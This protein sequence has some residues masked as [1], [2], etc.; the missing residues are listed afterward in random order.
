MYARLLDHV[1]AYCALLVSLISLVCCVLLRTYTIIELVTASI[2]RSQPLNRPHARLQWRECAKLPAP[3]STPQTA[4]VGGR[5]YVGAGD[6]NNEETDFKVFS[7]DEAQDSWD[8]LPLCPVRRFGLGQFRGR[9]VA[10]GGRTRDGHGTAKVFCYDDQAQEWEEYIKPMPT[11]RWSLCIVT[12]QSA[13]VACGGK[14]A[15]NEYCEIV[16]LYTAETH[17][18]HVADALPIR[19]SIMKPVTIG[20][21]CYLM[22]GNGVS[23]SPTKAVLYASMS[24]LIKKAVKA[25]LAPK[26]SA[27]KDD[28][29]VWK[30][31]QDA[32][33]RYSAPVCLGETLLTVGGMDSRTAVSKTVHAFV[34]FTNSWVK[35]PTSDLPASVA[36]ATCV[37]LPND[38]L[39][40]CGGRHV[41]SEKMERVYLGSVVSS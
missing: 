26:Q 28:A 1:Y 22:G 17:Q 21:T 32:P 12:T 34:P 24:S 8:T 13:V 38:N 31:L 14:T 39:L 5:V 25:T 16:E 41:M 6:T 35:M 10:V 40:V 2:L 30:K 37:R 7:Y 9:L 36:I 11:V 33:L 27:D 3:M 19:C 15:L 23:Q 20:D 18:W 29:T 4:V